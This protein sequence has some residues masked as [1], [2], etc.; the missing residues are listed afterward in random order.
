MGLSV[1][2]EMNGGVLASY[3][4]IAYWLD[5]DVGAR[6]AHALRLFAASGPDVREPAHVVV[7]TNASIV[8][9]G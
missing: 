2:D 3:K 1:D 7:R 8:Q 5:K 4:K 6:L 9:R